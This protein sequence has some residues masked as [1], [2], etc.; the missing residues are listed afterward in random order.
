MAGTIFK[1]QT[2]A[3]MGKYVRKLNPHLLLTE[4]QSDMPM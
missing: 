1:E 2:R 4:S 3:S